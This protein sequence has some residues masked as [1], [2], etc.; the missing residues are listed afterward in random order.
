MLSQDPVHITM[1]DGEH[2]TY[3]KLLVKIAP[4]IGDQLVTK[5]V[6]V[7]IPFT[8]DMQAMDRMEE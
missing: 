3:N 8:L 2:L 4:Q 1:T 5:I 7:G 6:G